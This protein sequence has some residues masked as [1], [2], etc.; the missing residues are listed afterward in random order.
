[1]NLEKR[2][3]GTTALVQVANDVYFATIKNNIKSNVSCETLLDYKN[4]CLKWLCYDN[5][6]NKNQRIKR[7]RK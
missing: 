1:M 7:V 3:E 4:I 6:R 5:Q 2:T